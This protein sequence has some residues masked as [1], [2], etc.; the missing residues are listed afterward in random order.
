VNE[1]DPADILSFWRR[2][3][4]DRWFASDDAFDAK[5][6][7]RFLAVHEAAAAGRFDAWEA[8]PDG[9]FA[10]LLLLDQFPRNMFRGTARAF[11]TD[12][13]A[14]AS[15]ERALQRGFDQRFALPERRFFYLPFMH[16]EALADQQRCLALCRLADD[17]EGVR[18]AEIHADIIRR[19]GRFPHRNA[20]LGRP[21]SADEQAFL[22]NGGFDG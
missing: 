2:A 1:S 20:A 9:A 14:R 12:A 18:Y 16:S 11:A 15:A 3:G 22:D 5:I 13:P 8:E 6:R 4:P 7:R 21:T 17:P 10:L 19:F